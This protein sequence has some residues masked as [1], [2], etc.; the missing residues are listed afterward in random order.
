[1]CP[2]P[3]RQP[4]ARSWAEISVPALLS[5]FRYLASLAGPGVGLIP[6]VKANAYGHGIDIVAPALERAG[7]A[8]LGV[9]NVAEA[10]EVRALGC[11]APILILGAALRDEIP[12]II[13]AGF[14]ATISSAD[15]VRAFDAAA[16][17]SGT[18]ALV[19]IKADT[20]MGR[21]GVWHEEAAPVMRALAKA[22][23]TTVA[24]AMTHL[25]S[26][27]ENPRITATQLSR[28]KKFLALADTLRGAAGP[29]PAHY[30]N[31]AGLVLPPLATRAGAAPR[32]LYARP[33]ISLYG[34][35]ATP[36]MARHLKPVMSWK[37]RITLVK[38]YAPGQTISY[39]AEYRVRKPMRVGVVAAGYADGYRRSFAVVGWVLCRGHRCA[40]LGRV[41]MDQIMVDLTGVRGA[42]AD[43]PVE[44]MGAA[45][46]ADEL[47]GWADTISYGIF[48]GIGHRVKRVASKP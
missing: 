36:A 24:A 47:A 41:T 27:G 17:R 12:E 23:H 4:P 8:M 7:A 16:R 6:A 42:R 22:R 21:L 5:N 10:I 26:A 48:T 9:A 33:G 34:S 35:P 43:D 32:T 14:H 18:R 3:Q 38:N 19:H 29:I 31:S 46:S 13:R 30:A 11:R 45:P 25:S 28:F 20:G 40:V 44:L 1:L 15:E 39:G 37:A 2:H